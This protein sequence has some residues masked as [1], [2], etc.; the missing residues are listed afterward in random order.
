MPALTRATRAGDGLEL[1]GDLTLATAPQLFAE[2]PRFDAGADA[3]IDLRAIG[4]VDSGGL[5]LLLH[6]QNAAAVAAARLT[7]TGAPPQLREMAKITG[8][9]ALL[10]LASDNAP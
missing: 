7:Y 8:A 10:N 6:W 9:E 2:T 3:R 5:A 4:D 1:A